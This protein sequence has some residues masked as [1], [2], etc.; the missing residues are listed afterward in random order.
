MAKEQMVRNKMTEWQK[1][2]GVDS[3]EL[4]QL[5]NYKNDWGK[6]LNICKNKNKI[7]D[8]C[9]KPSEMLKNLGTVWKVGTQLIQEKYNGY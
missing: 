6:I 9:D 7:L 3:V 5:E 8:Q 1:V 2:K 4:Q